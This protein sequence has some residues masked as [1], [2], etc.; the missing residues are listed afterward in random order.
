MKK[1]RKKLNTKLP[2]SP[3]E[4]DED[5]IDVHSMEVVVERVEHGLVGSLRITDGINAPML[6]PGDYALLRKPAKLSKKDFVLYQSHEAY[7][8]RRIIKYKEDDIYVAG[9]KEKEYHIIHKDDI[10]GK[11]ISRERKNKRLS[12][13]LTPRKRIYT[14]K[15]V[16]LAYFR[17]KNRITDYEQEINNESLELA[18][19]SAAEIKTVFENKTVVKY[20]IDLDSDLKDFLN[21]DTLVQELQDA[22]NESAGQEEITMEE[23]MIPEALEDS[24]LEDRIFT[25]EE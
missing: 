1:Y 20:D 4:D 13:S 10:V 17:L 18:S 3:D 6:K 21:P 8:L 22:M 9:D 7:F 2:V 15:K 5:T 25:E 24:D 11:V 14:F 23:E 12:F 19:Q 16:N